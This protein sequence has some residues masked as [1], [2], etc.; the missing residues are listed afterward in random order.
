L[1]RF[2]LF[3]CAASMA[4]PLY[5]E[6][7]DGQLRSKQGDLE[8]VQNELNRKKSQREEAAR[9]ANQLGAQVEKIS[10]ELQESRRSLKELNR[11]VSDT[12]KKRKAT[13][14]RLWASR[15]EIGQWED[16][17]GRELALYYQHKTVSG[18]TDF[19]A[20][21][22]RRA[23][24]EDKVGG[25]DFAHQHHASVEGVRDELVNVEVDLQKLR[26]KKEKEEKR[27]QVAQREMRSLYN[28][29]QGRR[30]V[31]ERDIRE[32]QATTRKLQRMI[33]NLIRKQEDERLRGRLSSQ[34]QFLA[35]SKYRGNL[36]WPVQGAVIERYG[37]TKHPELD[38][39]V[40]SNGV[41]LRPA[42]GAAV[43]AVE[44]GEVVYAG[45]FMSYGLMALVQHP[46]NLYSVYGRL[47]RLDVAQGKKISVGEV[48]G[49]SGADDAGRA[50]VYFEL[51]VGGTAVDPL[52][53]LK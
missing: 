25:L 44:K 17:L 38:T 27:V 46:D 41:T 14:E 45:E 22:Y 4:A 34:E 21:A 13:E 33:T 11:Q 18:V 42:G 15:L 52:Q 31:L 1:K 49:N 5:P 9:R 39:Y 26:L 3:L 28:T 10:R 19:L 20:L 8:R 35:A 37:R 32:L 12:E 48:L 47:G 2:I 16:V 7:W 23:A 53:W 36:P 30:A 50:Q 24:L 29:A 43:R 6:K 51:R 40:F